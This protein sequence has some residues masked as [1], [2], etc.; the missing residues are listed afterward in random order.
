MAIT[1]LTLR[2]TATFIELSPQYYTSW[3]ITAPLFDFQIV[4]VIDL[5]MFSIAIEHFFRTEN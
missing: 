5:L 1:T 3:C 4:L 2:I